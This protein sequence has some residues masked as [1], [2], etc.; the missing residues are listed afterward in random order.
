[1]IPVTNDTKKIPI[2]DWSENKTL[3]KQNS[4]IEL[5]LP[6]RQIQLSL[7]SFEDT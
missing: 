4:E 2:I 7:P 3:W 6:W 1:M 5:N